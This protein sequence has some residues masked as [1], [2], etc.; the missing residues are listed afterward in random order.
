MEGIMPHVRPQNAPS[1]SSAS[2]SQRQGRKRRHRRGPKNRGQSNNNPSTPPGEQQH[3][4]PQ[5]RPSPNASLNKG[6]RR[7]PKKM[8]SRKASEEDLIDLFT[9]SNPVDRKTTPQPEPQ[10]PVAE[11]TPAAEKPRRR[12]ARRSGKGHKGGHPLSASEEK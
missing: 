4:K 7:R 6:S 11:V 2:G 5:G 9:D 12:R 1:T 10:V 3:S 8:P